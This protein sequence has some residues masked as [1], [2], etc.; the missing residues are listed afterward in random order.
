MRKAMLKAAK[1]LFGK[2]LTGLGKALKGLASQA[3]T[4]AQLVQSESED[5]E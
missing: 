1:S 2:K 4:T 5:V 3:A